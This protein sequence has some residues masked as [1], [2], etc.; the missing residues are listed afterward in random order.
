M[1][2]F[3][4]AD[5]KS[6]LTPA[7]ELVVDERG[8]SAFGTVYWSLI[9]TEP[10]PDADPAL[11]REYCAEK[12]LGMVGFCWSRHCS[13]FA[14]ETI[15]QA[16]EFAHAVTPAPNQPIPIFEIFAERASRHDMNWL[17]YGVG[18]DARIE[19][20]CAYW[21]MEESNHKPAE[22]PRKLPQWEI[23]IPLPARVGAQV[24]TVL[25]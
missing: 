22:G 24:A 11:I 20:A 4:H 5:R 18:V 17:D 8:L 7:Q 6:S 3:F 15:E 9:Q 12:A 10:P 1:Y 21:R 16:I 19:Y 14:A 23:L 2:K 25:F 13:L